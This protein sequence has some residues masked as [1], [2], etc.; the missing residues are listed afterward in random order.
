ML[1]YAQD[2]LPRYCSKGLGWAIL[3]PNADPCRAQWEAAIEYDGFLL[4]T[5]TYIC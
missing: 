4:P 3:L 1:G 5:Q 2:D